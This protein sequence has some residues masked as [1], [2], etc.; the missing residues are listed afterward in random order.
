MF[1]FKLGYFLPACALLAVEIL[2]AGCLRDGFIRFYVG[3]YLVV[4]LIY[5][6]VRTFT[7]CPV[8]KTAVGVWIFSIV[9]EI[10]QFFHLIGHLGLGDSRI[11]HLILGSHF[12]WK[13]LLAY[14]AGI[15]TV[16]LVE[17]SGERQGLVS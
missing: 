3:D 9:V 1:T 17:K 6:I 14:T 7:A 2:I 13:D 11:A 10:S 16:L 5:C 12:E 8:L 4:I 15:G